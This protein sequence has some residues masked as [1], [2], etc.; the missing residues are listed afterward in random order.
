MNF[1]FLASFISVLHR[2]DSSDVLQDTSA[3]I[4]S[5]SSQLAAFLIQA[6]STKRLNTFEM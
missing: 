4:R 2:Q 1:H 5:R 3:V 6:F